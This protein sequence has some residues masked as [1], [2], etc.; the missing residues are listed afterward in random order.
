MILIITKGWDNMNIYDSSLWVIR[1]YYYQM[2]IADSFERLFK[3][4]RGKTQDDWL[5]F[6]IDQGMLP[7]STMT[8]T[9]WIKWR[10]RLNMTEHTSFI[11]K[12]KDD[13]SGPDIDLYIFPLNRSHKKIMNDLDG[14]NGCSFQTYVLLF[15][16]DDLTLIKQKA[17]LLHEYHHIARL[18]HQGVNERT[19]SLLESMIM[20][21][22]A[23]W[24]VQ[25]RLGDDYLAPWTTLYGEEE[26]LQWW[27]RLY[28]G[29]L[30]MT[31]RTFHYPFLYGEMKGI[32]PLMGYQIG[33]FLVSQF[34]KKNPDH[35]SLKILKT[36]A[37][38]FI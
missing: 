13:F 21:G 16:K 24:E 22:L 19:I 17:L 38:Q 25:K 14:K 12:L 34:M 5:A 2:S 36:P 6:L 26:I 31:G 4:D 10:R 23:E 9:G 1:H 33:Y 7:I 8:K 37:H 11:K 20:E 29:N 15:W 18:H 30:Q 32:P 3:Q 35:D 28:K 27:N